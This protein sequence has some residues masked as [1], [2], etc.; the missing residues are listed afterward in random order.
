MDYQ[1]R[2]SFLSK[3]SQVVIVAVSA[4]NLGSYSTRSSLSG[5][6]W[7]AVTFGCAALAGALYL[8]IRD[9]W[10]ANA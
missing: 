2:M 9:F 4:F 5:W 1:K 6:G 3:T 10:K 8:L 7:T